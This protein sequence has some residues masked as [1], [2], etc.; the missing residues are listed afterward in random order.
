MCSRM[1]RRQKQRRENTT[2][3]V[4]KN[5]SRKLGEIRRNTSQFRVR[6]RERERKSEGC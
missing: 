1:E 6:E 3:N 5:K 2:Q 4:R